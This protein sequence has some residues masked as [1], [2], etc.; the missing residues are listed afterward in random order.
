MLGQSGCKTHT[1]QVELNNTDEKK[2]ENLMI[3]FFLHLKILRMMFPAV[4]VVLTVW[5][6]CRDTS[7][8]V[9]PDHHSPLF[10]HYY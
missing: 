6:T 3:F 1:H 8:P 7:T 10:P 5:T 9:H 4:W 2:K